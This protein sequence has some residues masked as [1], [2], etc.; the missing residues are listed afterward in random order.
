MHDQNIGISSISKLFCTRLKNPIYPGALSGWGRLLV[1]ITSVSVILTGYSEDER[2][3]E[4]RSSLGLYVSQGKYSSGYK[5][6]PV[7]VDSLTCTFS[8]TK[9]FKFSWVKSRVG[10]CSKSILTNDSLEYLEATRTTGGMILIYLSCFSIC[11]FKDLEDIY[12][13][14]K[15]VDVAS[16]YGNK[17]WLYN[18]TFRWN[19]QG[20]L[21]AVTR[22]VWSR[23]SGTLW[24][25][26]HC[27]FADRW[28]YDRYS[29]PLHGRGTRNERTKLTVETSQSSSSRS[30][31]DSL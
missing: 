22:D 8:L 18:V 29:L 15:S 27:R 17:F 4:V 6:K 28:G 23:H 19:K 11:P 30:P 13:T 24:G 10:S 1:C 26:P 3:R 7:A 20:N 14:V 2:Y 12:L 31:V 25:L 16:Y 5:R 9:I 21:E